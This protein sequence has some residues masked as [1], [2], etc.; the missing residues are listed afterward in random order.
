ME[1]SFQYYAFISYKR[2]DEKWAKWL[3]KRLESY[4]LPTTIRKSKSDL[5]TRLRPVFLDQ[6][7]IQPGFLENELGDKLKQSR[8]LIVICSPLSAESPWVGKEISQF[9]ALGR[10]DKIIPF[11]VDGSP[12][13]N[14]AD[15]ECM[16][17]ILKQEL[18]ELLG[19]NV[20]EQGNEFWFIKREKAVTRLLSKILDVSFDALWHRHRR[21]KIRQAIV[22][23]IFALLMVAVI[24]G[25][26]RYNQ[27]FDMEVRLE[28]K[29]PHNPKLPYGEGKLRLILD[30]DTLL[31]DVNSNQEPI[32]FNNI[33]GKFR[34]KSS[35]LFF[36][37]YGYNPIDTLI[38]LTPQTVLTICRDN[39]WGVF[40]GVVIDEQGTP[41]EDALITIDE[42]TT[43]TDQSGQFYI[44]IPPLQQSAKKTISTYKRGY[45]NK[46]YEG[47]PSD[48]HERTIL[49]EKES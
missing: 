22:S 43:K 24:V 46:K 40:K 3:Q 39:T 13:S 37:M 2:E 35:K 29:T 14:N 36:E 26:W 48:K 7:D 45:K 20:N 34:Q 8:H 33:P 10:K 15:T 31:K 28:E 4:R 44:K 38:T 9:I 47:A 27:P 5:P 17:P 21:R 1:S 32:S 19:V 30:K 42:Q 41:V 25:V 16:H 12:Y 6:T 11:I 23:G 18:P 49:L